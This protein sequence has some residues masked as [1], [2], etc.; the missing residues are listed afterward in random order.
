MAPRTLHY[1]A[2]DD[3]VPAPRNPKGHDLDGV[4]A[5][6]ARFG[7]LE[8]LLEDGRTG[9]LI[10]GHGRL[11]ALA[12]AKAAGVDP[13]EGVTVR[14]GRWLVPVVRG[15]RSVDAAEAEAALVAVNRLVE[16]GGW[17]MPDLSA[18]L[19]DLRR[20]PGGLIG[21]GYEGVDVDAM[22]ASLR[23]VP[24]PAMLAEPDATPPLPTKVRTKRGDV[25]QLGRHRL[26]C[27]DV[28]AAGALDLVCAG[29]G[30]D[31]LLVDP[32]YCSGGFQESKRSSGSIGSNPKVKRR[33][34]ND[35]LSTRGYV[36]LM[37]AMLGAAAGANVAMVYVFT[38]WRMW[39]NL[40][41]VVESTGYGVRQMIVWD[42]G[43]P[44][45]GM[46][47][48]AQ[49]ELV[50]YAA[51]ASV[52]FDNHKAVGNVIQAARTGNPLHPT[53]KPVDL[54]RRIIE[55]SDMCPV[56]LDAMAGS[57]STLIAAEAE[58][59]TARLVELDP[60]HC[61]V[62]ARRYQEAT[63]VLPVLERTG[64]TVDFVG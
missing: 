59:R 50:M 17:Q 8:P 47:W 49:H 24:A 33:V 32:P 42:K 1:V 51:S 14:G 20:S 5:S 46:G 16:S 6:M 61:D 54:L 58:S 11:E 35:T 12:E 64:R 28:T 38:D 48:R 3:L 26:L 62:I 40:F 53:Q 19:D 55:V 41:D 13:P 2:L 45:M 10:S 36:A 9:R 57:G 63:G 18:M 25:Y 15:W 52:K 43:T 44:G 60:A 34:A 30:A 31:M 7:Y 37:R 23:P 56:V 27:G 39:V 29:E 21:T 4:R 22:L